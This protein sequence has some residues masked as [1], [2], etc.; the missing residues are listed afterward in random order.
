MK[1]LARLTLVVFLSI[2]LLLGGVIF[3]FYSGIGLP[4]LSSLTGYKTAQNSKVFAS[5]GTLLTELHGDE[6]REVIAL[7]KIPDHLQEAVIAIEDSEFFKHRGISWKA[8]TRALWANVVKGTVV[9]GGSTITQQYVKNAYVG[10]KRTLWRKIQEANLAYQLEK[11]YSKN[12]I[13]ELYL[14]D[15]YFGEGCYGIYTA[16]RKYFGKAPDQLTLAECAMLAGMVRSPSYYDPYKIPQ[17]VQERRNLVLRKM[18]QQGFITND[19]AEAAMNEPISLAPP[20]VVYVQKQ[21]P[22]FC[23]YITDLVRRTYGDQAAFRGGLRIYTTIDLNLQHMAENVLAKML[24]PNNG[25]DAAIACI[26]PRTGY[27]KA[28]V[29]GKNYALSQFNVAAQGHRQAG[30]AFK[31]FVLSRAMADGVSPERT[32]DSSSP[33]KINLPEGGVWVVKNYDGH[34]SGSMTVR[35]ATIHSV[36]VVFAQLIMDVGPSRV[37]ALARQMGITTD[38]QDNPAIA[39]GGLSTGVTPLEMASAF[40]T[41]ANNGIHAVPRSIYKVTDAEGNVITE[42]KP[43]THGVLDPMVAA[44]VN[45]LLQDVVSSGTATGARIGR[46]QAG[47]TGTTEDHADAWFV[48]YTPDLVTAV[49]VGYPQGSISM[50]GMVGGGLPA[51]IWREYMRQALKNTP[52]TEFVKLKDTYN[53]EEARPQQPESISVI[54]CDES[55]L[56]ATPNCPHTHSQEFRRGQEPTTFCNIHKSQPSNVVPNV[57]GMR[58]STAM[59]TLQQAGFQVSAVDE[60]SN[61]YV[62]GIVLSQTPAAGTRLSTGSSVTIAVSKGV[63]Q[64]SVPNVMGM[65]ELAARGSITA[66]GFTPSVSYT[67]GSQNNVV[68]GQSPGPGTNLPVGT[69]VSITVS[70]SGG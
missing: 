14:N 63:I 52:P 65:T 59:T 49:W 44:R 9:Q 53:D 57:V 6:N 12:K 1:I 40:G 21:A 22:Y 30:S 46:P 38:F 8:V 41:L 36:N 67:S 33:R 47:K 54:V 16:S 32:Y 34:G 48:G 3:W 5:D 20:N 60:P 13:L 31:V 61:Q 69:L 2:A 28:I 39:L 58:K 24:K 19:E 25:P 37:K 50:G 45:D 35:S 56:L 29:G 70:K 42:N 17:S 11:K 10:P 7:E 43:E 51:D 64:R 68:V 18:E 4:K 15:I 26:D 27:L 23:D 62:A 66:A 55:G